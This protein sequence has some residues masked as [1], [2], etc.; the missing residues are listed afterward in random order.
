MFENYY[1]MMSFLDKLPSPEDAEEQAIC[2]YSDLI[3]DFSLLLA[4]YRM[5]HNMT[6]KDLASVLS[7]SQTMVSQ[8]ESGAR[9]I[10]LNT[11]CELASKLGKKVTLSYEDYKTTEQYSYPENDDMMSDDNNLNFTAA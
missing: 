3:D 4:H 9:N 10:S 1:D 5:E 11:L 8:Y 6:Q 2:N 7:V